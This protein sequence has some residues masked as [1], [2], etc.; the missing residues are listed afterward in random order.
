MNDQEIDLKEIVRFPV[1]KREMLKKAIAEAILK[2][3][4][5]NGIEALEKL[6]CS[7]KMFTIGG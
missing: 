6:G 1:Y 4:G 7:R 2:K 3:T 5:I